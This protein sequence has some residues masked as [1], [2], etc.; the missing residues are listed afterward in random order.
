M[1]NHALTRA[2]DR[3]QSAR[4][5]DQHRARA[6]PAGLPKHRSIHQL[7]TRP[8]TPARGCWLLLFPAAPSPSGGG[9]PA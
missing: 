8:R 5:L 9:V 2:A 7:L 1:H 3:F 4:P 6:P